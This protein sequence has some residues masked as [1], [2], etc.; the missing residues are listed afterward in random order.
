MC[1]NIFRFLAL[2]FLVTTSGAN[3]LR[4]MSID[5]CPPLTPRTQQPF[6]VRTLRPDDIK[7]IAGLGDSYM[8]G[9]RMFA[10]NTVLPPPL[11]M[12]YRGLSYAMGG[13][14]GAKTVPKFFQHYSPN[15][16]GASIGQRP[17]SHC[18][19]IGCGFG[20]YVGNP[21]I[22]NVDQLNAALSGAMAVNLDLE[23]DYLILSLRRMHGLDF[24]NDWKMIT[25]NIGGNDQCSICGGPRADVASPEKYGA[26]V[27]AAVERIHQNVPRVIVNLL[28]PQKMSKVYNITVGRKYCY[29]PGGNSSALLVNVCECLEGQNPNPQA[30]DDAVDGYSE[31][32]REIHEYYNANPDP[33][34]G[35][36]YTPAD[37][38]TST[39]LLS[40]VLSNVDC[41]HP[42]VVGHQWLAKC[43]WN[44]LF[45]PL[46]RK[47][48]T[49]TFNANEK[50]YCPTDEDT[51]RID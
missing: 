47:R 17:T 35:V 6:D 14:P 43:L 26:F 49:W 29:P 42:T 7:A 13:N 22:P 8:A 38:D 11:I 25:L 3:A 46:S 20:T 39:Y 36:I 21:Y 19:E 24:E 37:L 1:I 31:K 32:L 44:D 2:S 51:I 33:G 30:M 9:A 28:G 10:E 40:E 15:I 48:K 18:T 50:I 23:L 45:F 34:F 12:E 16:T 5:Q 41:I 27:R 4:V